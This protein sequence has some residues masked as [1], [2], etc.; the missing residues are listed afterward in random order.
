[1]GQEQGLLFRGEGTVVNPS[2]SLLPKPLP[3]VVDWTLLLQMHQIK[4]V[5]VTE[6]PESELSSA[7]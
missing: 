1:M 4:W 5:Y 7:L 3:I 2:V 6:P